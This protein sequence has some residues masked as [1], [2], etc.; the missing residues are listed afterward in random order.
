M[1][2]FKLFT[3]KNKKQEVKD[4]WV[5]SVFLEDLTK[6]ILSEITTS[7]DVVFDGPFTGDILD[8]IAPYEDLF[9]VS[10]GLPF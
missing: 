3:K 7:E 1:A 5:D 10:D 2:L 9:D 6:E 8:E 4:N